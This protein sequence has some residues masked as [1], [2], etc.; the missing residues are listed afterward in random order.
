MLTRVYIK[1]LLG[2]KEVDIELDRGLNIITGPSGAG[3]SVFMGA[4]LANFGLSNQ[5]AT[6]CE[7]ELV[8]PK[9]LE[10]IAYELEDEITIKAIKKDRVR[11]FID[12]QKISK[13]ALKEMFGDY[14]SYI[15][16]RQMKGFENEALLEVVDNYCS[17]VDSAFVEHLSEYK[18]LY[19]EYKQKEA[20]LESLKEKIKKSNERVEFLKYEIEKIAS[21]NPKEGEYEEL[22]TIKKQLSKIDKIS[23]IATRVDA[24]FG[25]EDEVYELFEMLG[26]DSSY[27]SDA[28]NQLRSD[29]EEVETLS[30]ELAEVNIEE[31][32]NR[33]EEL[34]SLIKRFGTISEALEYLGEKREELNSFETINEDLTYLEEFL[35]KRKDELER[36]ADKISKAR[37]E[38]AKVIEEK[39][40]KY[41]KELKLPKAKFIF[42]K[43]SLY[44]LGNDE[45]TI[46]LDGSKVEHLSGGEFNRVRLALL[47]VNADSKIEEGVIILD[48][49]DANVSGDESIAIANMI[50]HLSKSYQIFAISHQPHLSSKANR[51]IF[52]NKDSSGSY[53]KVLNEDERV[54]EIARII[55]G[56]NFD[57]ESLEFAKKI[58]K[59]RA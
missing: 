57:K 37:R 48:E 9:D 54:K 12:G 41:L 33:L 38:G 20:E 46:E 23:E 53:A 18:S 56:E 39:L 1:K 11:F 6:L 7:V 50:S 8:K 31:V 4:I 35:A 32:L 21:L 36:L 28:M 42:S 14:I 15:S 22:L 24:L 13:K 30:E 10:S 27:F 29:L 25:Y 55:G 59:P 40:F 26:K 49:I 47:T 17:S 45:L 51:H 44:E 5:E 3:K 34:N 2:F 52:I 43:S 58:M 16:V 19:L